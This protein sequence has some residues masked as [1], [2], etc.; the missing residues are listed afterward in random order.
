MV[1]LLFGMVSL[2]DSC[3]K[4]KDEKKWQKD[5]KAAEKV[6]KIEQDKSYGSHDEE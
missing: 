5:K 2:T 3:K 1:I 6:K 4:L